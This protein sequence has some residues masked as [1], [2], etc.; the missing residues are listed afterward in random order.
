MKLYAGASCPGF[1]ADQ[2]IIERHSQNK[3]GM[4]YRRRRLVSLCRPHP[5]DILVERIGDG[6]LASAGYNLSTLWLNES[7]KA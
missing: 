2:E 7:P 3:L 1:Q 5:I 6:E 4:L